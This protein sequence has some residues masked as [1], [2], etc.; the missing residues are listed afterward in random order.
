MFMRK[1]YKTIAEI[2]D[3]SHTGDGLLSRMWLV[4]RLADYFAEDNPLFDRQRFLDAC[5]GD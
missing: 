4:N 5:N 2:I 1:H 3:S